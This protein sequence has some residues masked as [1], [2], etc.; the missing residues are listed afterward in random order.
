MSSEVSY[1]FQWLLPIEI[2]LANKFYRVNGFR[3]K[4]KR[5]ELCGVIRDAKKQIIAS[6][7]VREYQTFKLLAGVA[8]SPA[9]QRQGVARSLLS[10]MSNQFGQNL[11]TFPYEH[12]QALYQTIGFIE[13]PQ[14]QAPAAVLQLCKKYRNQGKDIVIMKYQVTK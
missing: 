1:A 9:F 2:P 11:Y 7:Y 8:V 4:A 12:L 14:M 10:N 13:V 6:A 5:N 3:R